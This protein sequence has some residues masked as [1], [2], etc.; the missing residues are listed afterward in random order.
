MTKVLVIY[1]GGTIG[2]IKDPETGLLN[3]FD[4]NSVYEHIPELNRLNVEI[5]TMSF[6]TPI[7][8]SEVTS[9]HWLE[10]AELIKK[11]YSSY[12]GFVVL[13]GTDTMSFTASA[14][15]YMIQ[16]LRKPIVFTGSQLSIILRI[17]SHSSSVH[18]T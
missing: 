16:G 6:K 11:A 2:M 9:K 4:F 13:H 12:D 18:S 14:L 7:D 5:D 3:S 8:S 10:L 15:S 17:Y 1:T